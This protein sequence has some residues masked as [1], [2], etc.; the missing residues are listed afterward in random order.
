MRTVFLSLLVALPAVAAANALF[1]A[2][3]LRRF[4]AQV[5]LIADARQMQLYKEEVAR[6]MYGA[7]AQIVL[8]GLPLVLFFA[9]LMLGELE[10]TDVGFVFVPAVLI[11]VLALVLKRHETTMRSIPT[12]TEE[13]E[14]ERKRVVEIW[15]RKPLPDW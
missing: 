13:L 3:R 4:A 9:G 2:S 6:Q 7:L 1:A 8:L 12:A 10:F 5:K 15:L 11:L 14:G